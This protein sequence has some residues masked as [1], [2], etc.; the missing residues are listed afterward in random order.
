MDV[1]ID[2]DWCYFLIHVKDKGNYF[3]KFAGMLFSGTTLS[4]EEYRLSALSTQTLY[5]TKGHIDPTFSL[6]IGATTRINTQDYT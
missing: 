3:G 4:V 6:S 5:S 2:P 1:L